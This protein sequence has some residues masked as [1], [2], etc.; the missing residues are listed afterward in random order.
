MEVRVANEPLAVERTRGQ[1]R[2]RVVRGHVRVPLAYRVRH[3][4]PSYPRTT[5]AKVVGLTGR[6][7]VGE[8]VA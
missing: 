5:V 6:H 8:Q 7:C 3:E 2:C 4:A 1:A